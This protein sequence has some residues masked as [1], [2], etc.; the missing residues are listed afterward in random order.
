MSLAVLQKV[1]DHIVGAGLGAGYDLR[2]FRMLDSRDA[3]DPYILV[4]VTGGLNSSDIVLQAKQVDVF[5]VDKIDNQA[6]ADQRSQQIIRLFR[7]D[8]VEPGIVKFEPLSVVSGPLFF[9][10]GRPYWR[11][12]MNVYTENE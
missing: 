12:S 5:L 6:A 3:P 8:G 10:D 4:R 9:D 2:Y 11:F 1:T 7:E